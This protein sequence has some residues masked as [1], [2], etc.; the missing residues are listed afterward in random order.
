MALYESVADAVMPPGDRDAL[1]RALPFLA[2]LREAPSGT[3]L[4]WADARSP[5]TIPSSSAAG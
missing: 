1:R 4:V 2:A 5:A 3:R